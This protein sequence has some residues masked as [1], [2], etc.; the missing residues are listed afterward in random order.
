MGKDPK[1]HF[2]STVPLLSVSRDHAYACRTTACLTRSPLLPL[3]LPFGR[4]SKLKLWEGVRD[5]IIPVWGFP[6]L[7]SW[8]VHANQTDYYQQINSSYV[9][10]NSKQRIFQVNQ[11]KYFSAGGILHS[12]RRVTF[13]G[14][15]FFCKS[16]VPP[17]ML[18]LFF[19]NM[20]IVFWGES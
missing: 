14:R 20:S 2:Y 17:V 18:W 12:C 8:G 16:P 1:K 13:L 5:S 10:R 11:Y 19:F 4:Q 15:Y 7:S 3:P 6:M 9:P